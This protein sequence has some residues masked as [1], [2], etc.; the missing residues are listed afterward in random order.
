M[1]AYKA[2]VIPFLK[3]HIKVILLTLQIGILTNIL[4]LLIPILITY[5]YS[6]IFNLQSNKSQFLQNIL[7]IIP[8]FETIFY[9]FLGAILLKGFLDFSLRYMMGNL[10]EQFLYELRGQLFE[11]Q[12]SVEISEYDKKGMGKYLLRYSGDLSSI[13]GFLTKGIIRFIADGFMLIFAFSI[14]WSVYPFLAQMLLGFFL[15]TALGIHGLNQLFYIITEKRRNQKSG[16][17]K[18]VNQRLMS[19]LTLQS[20]NKEKPELSRFK[21]RIKRLRQIGADYQRMTA[22][23]QSIIPVMMYSMIGI[24]L[25]F[26]AFQKK[27]NAVIDTQNMLFIVLLLIS[28]LPFFRRILGTSMIWKKGKISIQKLYKILSL[29]KPNTLSATDLVFEKGEIQFNNLTFNYNNSSPILNGLDGIIQPN[30]IN[31]IIGSTESGKTTLIKLLLGIYYPNQGQIL[32][33]NQA[34]NMVNPKS[35]RKKITVIADE[36]Q[37]YGNTVLE[38]IAY[39]RQ[40]KYKKRAERILNQIQKGRKNPLT[41]HQSI[42][43]NGSKLSKNERK[44]LLYARGLM[45]KKSILLIDEPFKNLDSIIEDNI[46]T[47]LAQLKDKKTIILFA[48]DLATL[49]IEVHHV[50][51]LD[52]S[53]SIVPLRKVG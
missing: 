38:A 34:S 15:L 12:L 16:L 25:Y 47:L 7:P 30:Q 46:K 14:L 2:I 53:S 37:L 21:K 27:S 4:T 17:L 40:K 5:S 3:K 49:D 10:G 28:L 36:W 41:I 42:G 8:S 31:A 32:I 13:H 39:G 9:C 51:Y 23:I 48:N 43:T 29:P 11:Y 26:I 20:F 52:K 44:I 35:W 6:L 18:F 45:T 22:L 24:V 1:E 50:L 33:D 19:M